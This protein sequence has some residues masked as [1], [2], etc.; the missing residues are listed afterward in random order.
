ML[1]PLKA[2]GNGECSRSFTVINLFR[3]VGEKAAAGETLLVLQCEGA[4]IDVNSPADGVVSHILSPVGAR[5]KEGGT[6]LL[7]SA[8]AVTPGVLVGIGDGKIQRLRTEAQ[9]GVL[10][11]Q[12]RQH[13]ARAVIPFD[14]YRGVSGRSVRNFASAQKRVGGSFKHYID[15]PYEH[16]QFELNQT[17]SD[18]ARSVIAGNV[19]MMFDNVPI[20]QYRKALRRAGE[21]VIPSRLEILAWAVVNSLKAH[22]AF[23]SKVVSASHVRRFNDPNLGFAIAL[24]ENGLAI[25]VVTNVFSYCFEE[26]VT[27]LRASLQEAR[28]E[29]YVATHHSLTITDMSCFG[30]TGGVPLIDYPATASLFIGKPYIRERGRHL[31]QLSLSFDHRLI[32]GAGAA[33]FLKVVNQNVRK[34]ALCAF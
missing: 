17:V 8:A 22:P 34:T 28:D 14:L 20:E 31:Y 11:P 10:A 5:V 13:G 18:D 30:V 25:A 21:R 12:K 9:E 23:C 33:L 26:F 24:P 6:L 15:I 1:Y 7:L 2:P 29:D 27:N 19:Q 4:Q 3:R 32:N 16:S